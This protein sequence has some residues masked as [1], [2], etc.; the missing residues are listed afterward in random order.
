MYYKEICHDARSHD[1]QIRMWKIW[2]LVGSD[3]NNNYNYL[4]TFLPFVL[5]INKKN[6]QEI[7]QIQSNTVLILQHVSAW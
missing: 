7:E 3:T 6:K 1:G 2:T 4:K 5:W